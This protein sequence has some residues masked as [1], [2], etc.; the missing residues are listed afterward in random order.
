MAVSSWTEFWNSY[1]D[2]QT[3]D[4]SCNDDLSDCKFIQ[5]AR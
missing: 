4:I 2:L 1:R 5:I 3:D